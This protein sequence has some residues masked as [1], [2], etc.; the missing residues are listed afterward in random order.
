ML[1]VK[2]TT[3]RV[4]LACL[5]LAAC[6]PDSPGPVGPPQ[7][8]GHVFTYTPP[9]GAPEIQSI[10]V[11]GTFNDWGETIAMTRQS[12]GSWRAV[13][14]VGDNRHLYKFFINGEWPH[15]MCYNE[16]WGD[17][18]NDYWIDPDATGC[19]DDGFGGGNAILGG[20]PAMDFVHTPTSSTHVSQAGGR[21]SIRFRAN[22]N[23]V[24]SASVMAGGVTYAM[25][26]QFSTSTQEV[27]RASVPEGTATYHITVT[28]SNGAEE[29]GP[30]NVPGNLFRAVP[31]VGHSV[32][33]QIFPERFWNGDPTND[34]STV[35]TDA[36]HFMHPSFRGPEPVLT[37]EWD[38]PMLEHHCCGQYFGGDLKGVEQRLGHLEGLGVSLIYM[39]PIFLGGSAHGYDTFDYM[40]VAP[41]FGGNQALGDLL[42]AARARDMRLMWDFVPNHVGVGHWAFQ[43]AVQNGTG[44][45]YW[46]WFRFHVPANQIQVGNGQHYDGW[47]GI[48]SLP[49]LN[50][51][52]A[53]VHEHLMDVTRHWTEFGLDAIRV[54][55]PESIRNPAQFFPAWRAVAKSVNPDVYLIGEVW[56]RSPD[57]VQGNR[58][59]ALMNY[60]IGLDV[61]RAYAVGAMSAGA[62]AR[63]MS[64]LYMAYPEASVAMLFNLISSHDTSR[65]LTLLGGGVLGGT[66]SAIALGRQRVATAMLYALPGVPVTFQGD[67]CAFLGTA[68]TRDQHRYPV[69]WQH[70]DQAMLAHYQ[71][72]GELKQSVP[73][74]RSPV[75]RSISSEG[76]VVSFYRGEPG[77]GEVFALFN[78]GQ[79]NQAVALPSGN[80]VD[81]A[82]GQTVSGTAQ[83]G[84]LVWMYLQRP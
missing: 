24:Q 15:D 47:W 12:D 51:S 64:L 35:T 1:Y 25:H 42:T 16:T 46:N 67:E 80:W 50:T 74:L 60:A 36:W 59:D 68:S 78:A 82:T 8:E 27:W 2:R 20:S 39:N 71:Q 55:V 54:D 63:E 72:L 18:V 73:A 17:P 6:S 79:Q 28:G 22:P 10:L 58:F 43:H 30:Y 26:R 45:P 70:C 7:A 9:S 13:A 40:Q 32:G 44:S 53:A 11:R 61:I 49:E 76:S 34:G 23:H 3:L 41:Y 52:N 4:A 5:A 33:Y 69:Q 62:A 66:P 81:A 14:N 75:I 65:L 29:F 38:G 19:E 84:S 57:W 56:G 83:V 37:T 48:G 31:W 77:A 21:V